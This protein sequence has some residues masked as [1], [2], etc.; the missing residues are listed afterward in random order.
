MPLQSLVYM[1]MNLSLMAMNMHSH[2]TGLQ[3]Q[4]HA[5]IYYTHSSFAYLFMNVSHAHFILRDV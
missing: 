3:V 2:N 1:Y 5:C 4:V